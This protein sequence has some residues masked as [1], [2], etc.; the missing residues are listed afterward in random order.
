MNSQLRKGAWLQRSFTLS[1]IKLNYAWRAS[2][3]ILFHSSAL[4][5]SF[6]AAMFSSRCASDDV[7]GIGNMTG[8]FCSNQA[9][10]SCTTLTLRRFALYVRDLLFRFLSS[11]SEKTGQLGRELT[12]PYQGVVPGGNRTHI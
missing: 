5:W 7:P 12:S 3:S 8:D 6:S 4:S 11:G 9:S 10:A 2:P 1:T